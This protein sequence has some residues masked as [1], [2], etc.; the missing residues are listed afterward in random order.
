MMP[1]MCRRYESTC[2]ANDFCG[3]HQVDLK[4]KTGATERFGNRNEESNGTYP[5][6]DM[7][8]M[9]RFS[10]MRFGVPIKVLAV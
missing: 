9:V 5:D 8:P 1:T 10:A 3:G 7:L 4:C 2:F 6:L